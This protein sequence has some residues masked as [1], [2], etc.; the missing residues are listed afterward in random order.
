MFSLKRD[1]LL[2]SLRPAS[3]FCPVP[4]I[5]DRRAWDSVERPLRDELI[6]RA[7]AAA[8][9][10]NPRLDALAM[11]EN[12]SEEYERAYFER[13]DQLRTLLCG[14]C[15]AGEARYLMPIAQRAFSI[16]EESGWTLKGDGRLH[17]SDRPQIDLHAAQT[18]ELMA[19]TLYLMRRSLDS[20]SPEIARRIRREL[21]FR[22]IRPLCAEDR[23]ALIFP[24]RDT[25][26]ATAA[27]M[28]AALLTETDG[29]ARWLCMRRMLSLIEDYMLTLSPDGGFLTGGL[30]AH[31]RATAALGDCLRMIS[32]SSG[33]EVELRDEPLFID[34]ALIPSA[35]HVGEGW[36]FNPG[37]DS[38][39]P[40]VPVDELFR[41]G[42]G[43]R[44]GEL[45]QLAAYLNRPG[46]SGGRAVGYG[47]LCT[48]L[49]ILY[50]ADLAREPARAALREGVCLRGMQLLAIRMGAFY[51]ALSGGANT[52][53]A[54]HLDV[55]D[56]AIYY[57]GKPVVIDP[58][59]ESAAEYHSVPSVGGVKQDYTLSPPRDE[60]DCRLDEGYF[61][62]SLGI[63]HAYPEAARL[64][65][66][67]RSLMMSA[68][69][70]GVRL[71]E[72]F[73]FAPGVKSEVS[74]HFVTP[75]A[76]RLSAGEAALGPVKLSWPDEALSAAVEPLPLKNS[77][78]RLLLGDKV[79]RLTLT[80]RQ[81][82]PGGN[83]T[84]IFRPAGP[85]GK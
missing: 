8:R 25:P 37:G 50:R 60:V 3:E 21:T 65:N 68:F 9:R 67:Q 18:A 35:L 51:A 73:D 84:F 66:W 16:C 54:D 62:I 1:Q 71:M 5:S 63:A 6:A 49:N 40:R 79:Y 10:E 82:V 75:Y 77:G 53:R 48:L 47:A 24:L 26:S 7:D 83:Y 81:K 27:L 17:E 29:Q 19:L 23:G 52:D 74:F 36:F 45:C 15:L 61:L 22:V 59:M 72:V 34:M 64:E 56:M 38:P 58:G 43:V 20:L 42:D 11:L 70:P 57:N 13:R 4:P 12:R 33:G 14:A 46:N 41:L 78:Q 28:C 44:S 30:E 32:L 55:G 69:E 76:A 2:L 80:T 85:D 31:M 39:R